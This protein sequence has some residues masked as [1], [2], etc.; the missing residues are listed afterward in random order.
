ASLEPSV[1]IAL[2]KIRRTL[3]TEELDEILNVTARKVVKSDIKTFHVLHDVSAPEHIPDNKG[4]LTLALVALGA[5]TIHIEECITTTGPNRPRLEQNLVIIL[6]PDTVKVK[7]AH[8]I[9]NTLFEP[10]ISSEKDSL[11]RLRDI[12]RTVLAMRRLTQN[13]QFY[14]INPH[15]IDEDDFKKRYSERENALITVVTETYKNLWY[16]SASGQIICKE[17]KTAGGEGGI[18]VLEQIRKTFIEE[19]E[20]LTSEHNTQSDLMNLRKLFF[21]HTDVIQ[22]AKLKENFNRVR[23]FPI[24]D[25]ST[26]L[27]QLIRA[28]V[29]RNIWCVFKMG[30]DE[31][32]KPDE[33]FSQEQGDLPLHIDLKDYSLITPEGARQRK[34]FTSSGIDP[35]KIKDN[36]RQLI[37][38]KQQAK[39]TDVINEYHQKFGEVSSKDMDNALTE[40]IKQEKLMT[41]KGDVDQHDKPDLTTGPKVV[42]YTLEQDDVVIIPSK[43]AEK[44]WLKIKSNELHLDGKQGAKALL[45]LLKRLGSLYQKGATSP[46]DSLELIDMDLPHGGKLKITI[47]DASPESMK[48]LAE[49]FEVVS[50][51]TKISEETHAY[52]DISQPQNNCLFIREL[53][54]NLQN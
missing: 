28:G 37:S 16:P 35:A 51:I 8:R 22:I 10:Q 1:N 54:K 3:S 9:Q 17:I 14:G 12:A 29:T 34:W 42:Y 46:I 27:D 15:K 48:N 40:L 24:L 44:G 43:A 30:N 6:V 49:L 4:K 11:L 47:S 39:I 19:K 25:S 13:P 50:G 21:K 53:Q 7:T 18:S 5:G 31:N 45:P 2:S 38:D 36:I 23:V 41:Y 20:L 32:I 33:F 52:L 26:V